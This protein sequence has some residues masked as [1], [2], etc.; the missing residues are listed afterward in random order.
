MKSITLKVV[1]YYSFITRKQYTTK[2]ELT[3]AETPVKKSISNKTMA[4]ILL[5][6]A[7][8]E[9]LQKAKEVFS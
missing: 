5:G 8:E 6:I 4:A 3:A 1:G 7:L 9:K 2:E